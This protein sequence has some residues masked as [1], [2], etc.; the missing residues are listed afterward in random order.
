MASCIMAPI[1]YL[2]QC[3]FIIKLIN[4]VMWHLSQWIIMK[5][6]NIPISKMRLKLVHWDNFIPSPEIIHLFS[7]DNSFVCVMVVSW[8]I[9]TIFNPSG[10]CLLEE[11]KVPSPWSFVT[12][13]KRAMS[14]HLK[15]QTCC[16]RSQSHERLWPPLQKLKFGNGWLTNKCYSK[17]LNKINSGFQVQFQFQGFNSNS[18]FNSTNFNS[19]SN[20]GIGIELQFQF[21]SWIDPNPGVGQAQILWDWW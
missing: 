12:T 1:H 19:N 10:F 16:I 6:L 13:P 20:S 9:V 2:K 18:I 21:R 3:R 11:N 15:R 14:Q 8:Y 5:D 17:S 7:I 4:K